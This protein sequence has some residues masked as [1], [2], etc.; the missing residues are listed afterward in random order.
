MSNKFQGIELPSYNR[1]QFIG[2]DNEL[3]KIQKILDKLAIGEKNNDR[4]VTFV[5]EV[6]TGKSWLINRIKDQV[7]D[8]NAI[9]IFIDLSLYKHDDSIESILEILREVQFQLTGIKD[10]S[11]ENPT[12]ASRQVMEIVQHY[13]KQEIL[14][15]LLDHVYESDWGLLT[16]IDQYLLSP[17][18]ANSR[19]MIVLAGRGRPYPWNTPEVPFHNHSR[20]QPFSKLETQLQIKKQT[21]N[22]N[23][24]EDDVFKYGG[25][26]PMHNYLLALHNFP[27]GLEVGLELIFQP[28]DVEDRPIVRQYLEALCTLPSFDDEKISWMWEHYSGEPTPHIQ[29]RNIREL[30]VRYGFAKWTEHKGGYVIDDSVYITVGNLLYHDNPGKWGELHSIGLAYMEELKNKYKNLP[31]EP[32]E[33]VTDHH[34]HDSYLSA[35]AT[36]DLIGRQQ[37]IDQVKTMIQDQSKSYV[38]YIYGPGGVGKT[39]L[40]KELLE[41]CNNTEQSGNMLVAT[42]LIDL[43]HTKFRTDLG[44]AKRISEVLNT[45]EFTTFNIEYDNYLKSLA[46][47]HPSSRGIVFEAFMND[48]KSISDKRRIVL[49]FDTAE[50]LL[51][52]DPAA[53]K[54]KLQ[55]QYLVGQGRIFKEL[56]PNLPN[57]VIVIAGRT[58]KDDALAS[59]NRIPAKKKLVSIPLIGLNQDEA[60]QYFDEITTLAEKGRLIALANKLK[61]I[62]TEQRKHIYQILSNN[63]PYNLNDDLKKNKEPKT[64]GVRPLWLSLVV[65]YLLIKGDLPSLERIKIPDDLINS[66]LTANRPGMELLPFI[67]LTTK[68]ATVEILAKITE[69]LYGE[70]KNQDFLNVILNS[71]SFTNLS[72]VKARREGKTIYITFH[73]EISKWVRGNFSSLV[74]SSDK[75]SLRKV[76][77]IIR[78]YLKDQIN[79]LEDDLRRYTPASAGIYPDHTERENRASKL[80]EYRVDDFYYQLLNT[81]NA[82]EA[83]DTYFVM[84]EDALAATDHSLEN[85]ITSEMQAY[86][87]D[88]PAKFDEKLNGVLF[89]DVNAADAAIRWLKREI[90]SFKENAD[91][92]AIEI[93]KIVEEGDNLSKLEYGIWK[94]LLKTYEGENT[95]K[96]FLSTING[97]ASDSSSSREKAI[98]ARALNNYGYR[99]RRQG[100]YKL[101]ISN[102]EKAVTLFRNTKIKFQEAYTRN[103]LAF[104]YAEIGHLGTAWH[105]AL[106]AYKI[107][108]SGQYDPIGLSLNTMAHILVRD[109]RAEEATKYA[110]QALQIFGI[111]GFTRGQG[112]SHIVLAEAERRTTENPIGDI[113]IER[114]LRSAISHGK[115]GIKIFSEKNQDADTKRQD[116]V[117]LIQ[118]YIET[119]CAYRDLAKFQRAHRGRDAAL[120]SEANSTSMF[121]DAEDLS[122]R[123][124]LLYRQI[125]AMINRAW[126][127]YYVMTFLE[128]KNEPIKILE[129]AEKLIDSKYFLSEEGYLKNL[130][131]EERLYSPILSLLGKSELLRGHITLLFFDNFS[132]QEKFDTLR[133]A[134]QHYARSL[135]YNNNF[136]PQVFRSLRR[137]KSRIYEQFR[138]LNTSELKVVIETANNYSCGQDQENLM[139][140]LLKEYALVLE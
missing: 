80:R 62:T 128:D 30:L 105:M 109:D 32:L 94:G 36:P 93:Q 75:N 115:E 17:F 123:Q 49:F 130:S 34:I 129:E 106:D 91:K 18:A 116:P 63:D 27:K 139:I 137:T 59:F 100:N 89:S 5:G 6:G 97:L 133:K 24:P 103:N 108:L 88:M 2:R 65:D 119:G 68:G 131:E 16:Y 7:K 3:Q 85:M 126:L 82:I 114:M 71:E 53:V 28:V 10:I 40:L 37:L 1:S 47:G 121:I 20:L 87:Y 26:I 60:I 33:S 84:A 112:L 42:N 120:E 135:C 41:Q 95:E 35:L 54:M 122:A 50:Q 110:K 86:I 55:D 102:Y 58:D 31:I 22:S 48:L 64:I 39:R 45:E 14:G 72:F 101:A 4:V 73:D 61:K 117:E 29:A 124:K 132:Q 70:T 44:I 12:E 136:S 99:A 83:F 15:L 74:T 69:E 9:P 138:E 19:T 76:F 77:E 57:C 8:S 90:L 98:L 43:F 11:S 127:K 125:D 67:G 78:K 92:T 51:H 13:A 140:R 52:K 25:G 134:T 46:H 104:A 21:F 111:T 118:A 66:V 38:Y 81:E 23:L 56:L 79:S 96:I 107:R 113:D